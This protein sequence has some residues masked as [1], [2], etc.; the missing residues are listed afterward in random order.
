MNTRSAAT[1]LASLAL[2]VGSAA[3]A[4][5]TITSSNIR[6]AD[7]AEAKKTLTGVIQSVSHDENSFVLAVVETPEGNA[8]RV[9]VRV[10]DDTHY[11]L[12]GE[13][14][15]MEE[16]LKANRTAKARVEDDVATNVNVSTL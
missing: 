15:T 13:D 1:A 4:T 9:T 8:E 5:N 7:D 16:A 12:D 10:N 14:S 3:L 6:L 2:L 11:I